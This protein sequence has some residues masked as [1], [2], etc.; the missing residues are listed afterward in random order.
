[1][2]SF[3]PPRESYPED[4]RVIGTDAIFSSSN[5]IPPTNEKGGGVIPLPPSSP[6]ADDD[7]DDGI[8]APSIYYDVRGEIHNVRVN[9]KYRISILYQGG[10]FA[11]G[12]SAPQRAM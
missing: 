10:I 12:R 5:V 7:D 1:M 2:A 9:G 6:P 8:P 11:I 3:L 4:G